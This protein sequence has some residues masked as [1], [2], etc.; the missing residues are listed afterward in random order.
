VGGQNAPGRV[1]LSS[2]NGYITSSRKGKES[3]GWG[4][5]AARELSYLTYY[6]RRN[7]SVYGKRLR[8]MESEALSSGVPSKDA[9]LRKRA[10]AKNE[11]EGHS[12]RRNV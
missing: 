6:L 3:G 2:G 9:M 8:T 10:E 11:G 5:L 4:L 7:I 1:L 12:R